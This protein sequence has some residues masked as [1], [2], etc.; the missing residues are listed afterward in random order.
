MTSRGTIVSH[1]VVMTLR[2]DEL[3]AVLNEALALV[4]HGDKQAT[5]LVASSSWCAEPGEMGELTLRMQVR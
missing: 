3:L 2:G 5:G 1:E 4:G